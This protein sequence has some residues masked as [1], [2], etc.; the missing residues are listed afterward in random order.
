M[1]PAPLPA[2]LVAWIG[3]A[4]PCVLATV[5]AD[6]QPVSVPCWYDYEPEDGHVILS[7]GRDARRVEHIAQNPMV[8][9]TVLG[10]DWYTHV[11]LLGHVTEVR[12]DTDLVDLDRL[13]MRYLGIPYFEREPFLTA[14][15][16][17]DSWH[18]FGS[19]GSPAP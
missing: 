5:R 6:G 17:I 16:E 10:D 19:P 3:A 14:V 12:E 9:L 18:T 7:M 11:S 15:V 4:R 8:A 2:D 1:P 13:S